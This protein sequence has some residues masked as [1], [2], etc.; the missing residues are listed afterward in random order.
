MGSPA[1]PRPRDLPRRRS[2]GSH[3]A[4]EG[5]A[6]KDAGADHEPAYDGVSHRCTDFDAD[7]APDNHL[8]DIQRPHDWSHVDRNRHHACPDDNLSQS[9][10][11]TCADGPL[12]ASGPTVT[13]ASPGS[14]RKVIVRS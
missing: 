13:R 2:A 1:A 7:H 5:D 4:K 3:H 9:V 6:G 10:T 14:T 8:D 12:K 11:V